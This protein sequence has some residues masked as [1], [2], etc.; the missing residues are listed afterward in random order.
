MSEQSPIRVRFIDHVTIVVK[1]LERSRQFYVETLGLRPDENARFEFWVGDTCFAI[2]T[3]AWFGVEYQPQA[4]S[5][6]LLQVDDVAAARS[7]LEAKGIVFDGETYDSGVCHMA[8]FKDPEALFYAARHLAHLNE[9]NRAIELLER[10]VAGGFFCFPALARDP[11]LD[12]L[13]KKPA[14]A[15]VLRQ[16]EAEHRQATKVFTERGGEKLLGVSA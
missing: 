13:R 14:F 6:V 15:E 1:N 3:P 8:D 12:P 5:I 9:T 10:A 11:W 16:A 2:W 7:E 4:N